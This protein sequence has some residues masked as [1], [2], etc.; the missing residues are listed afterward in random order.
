MVFIQ[1]PLWG[2]LI[3]KPYILCSQVLRSL[4]FGVLLVLSYLLEG[5]GNCM[6][7]CMVTANSANLI[8]QPKGLMLYGFWK[9]LRMT[10]MHSR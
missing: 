9:D 2:L 3:W 5:S 6:T 4:G 1:K 7:V 10:V 8:H